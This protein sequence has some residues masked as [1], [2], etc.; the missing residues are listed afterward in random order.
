MGQY[1][2]KHV[3]VSGFSY[4]IVPLTQLRASAGLNYWFTYVDSSCMNDA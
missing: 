2:P 1:G 4:I 3:G